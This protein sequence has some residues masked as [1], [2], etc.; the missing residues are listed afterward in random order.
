MKEENLFITPTKISSGKLKKNCE[1]DPDVYK[2]D[3]EIAILSERVRKLGG[4][5]KCSS[6]Q[7][8]RT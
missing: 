1:A 7:N 2:I 8:C 4:C 6:L 3:K 5:F